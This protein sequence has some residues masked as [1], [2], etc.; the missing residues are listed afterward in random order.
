MFETQITLVV[1]LKRAPILNA[2]WDC[3]CLLALD[4]VH[5]CG[6]YRIIHPYALHGQPR[7]RAHAG[8]PLTQVIECSD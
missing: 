5:V 8:L 6:V 1:Q 2:G 4:G 3:G 7:L